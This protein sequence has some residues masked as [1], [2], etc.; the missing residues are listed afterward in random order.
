MPLALNTGHALYGNL[1][2]LL[3]VDDDNTLK[4]FVT[5]GR[6][7]TKHASAVYGTGTWGRHA[8]VRYSGYASYGWDFGTEF[9]PTNNTGTLLLVFNNIAY[10]EFYN[11]TQGR[12]Y[13]VGTPYTGSYQGNRALPN[14]GSKN[15]TH[16]MGMAYLGSSG[17]QQL[18]ANASI[19]LVG[20]AKMLTLSRDGTTAHNL[21]HNGTITPEV[22]GGKLGDDS[23]SGVFKRVGSDDAAPADFDLVWAAWFDKV[24]T[25]TEISD[26]Y[27]SLGASN[28]FAL[29]GGAS[30]A[31]A[32]TLT[33]PTSGSNGVAS[34]N[35]TSGAN[36]TITGT[37]TVT[38]NDGGQ[39]GT[40]APTSVAISSGTPTA[41][42]T[43]TP[44]STGVKTISTTNNGGLTPASSIAYTSNAAGDVTAPTQTGT[45]TVGTVTSNSIQITWPAGAD[46]V[47]VTSYETSPDGT[48]WTDRGNVL[49]YTFTGLTAS[50]SYTFRVR[51][52]DAAG[53]VSTPAL[54]VTQ[55]TAAV[56]SGIITTPVMKNNTGTILA[57][58]A[59]VVV[60][61]YNATTGALVVRKT[62]LTSSAGGVVTLTDVAI[63]TGTA[64]SYEVVLAT[65]GR[66]L[67]VA[68]AT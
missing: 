60:N 68:T 66:R 26:L 29:V 33:G 16:A 11:S 3:G 4:D 67:P 23:T 49:T 14:I 52:K 64:Y 6:T 2:M 58:E 34:T 5:P 12:C 44:A 38:P 47:A 42:F 61:V 17:A 31:T 59:G 55:S 7:F 40:F 24:L 8:G 53:N 10:V 36:G 56:A 45:I 54:Q 35:F 37:V 46:N 19:A 65:N 21:Y 13:F 22:T 43:Y 51:A 27:T 15:G 48:T 39:G 20:G 50:T 32:T 1:K 63:V 41:S 25:P 57:S 30:A 9:K 18:S 28:S 62:G